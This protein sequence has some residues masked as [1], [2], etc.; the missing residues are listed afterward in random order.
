MLFRFVVV[1]LTACGYYD[2]LRVGC[3][4]VFGWLLL[5]IWFGFG[6]WY[7]AWLVLFVVACGLLAMACCG[8]VCE[9][10]VVV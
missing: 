5:T 2:C 1:W 8:F 7:G 4:I 3:L 6:L 9:V 10:F